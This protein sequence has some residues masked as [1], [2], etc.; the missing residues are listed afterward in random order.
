MRNVFII[1]LY[2]LAKSNTYGEVKARFLP[3]AQSML[4]SIV[5]VVP[6]PFV[7]AT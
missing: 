2:S 6:L 5:D 3:A 1:Y 7:P 4:L